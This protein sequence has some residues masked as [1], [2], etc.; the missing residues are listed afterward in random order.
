MQ[1]ADSEHYSKSASENTNLLTVLLHTS[2]STEPSLC[3][4]NPHVFISVII[5][6][7]DSVA[8]GPECCEDI[9]SMSSISLIKL[10]PTVQCIRNARMSVQIYNCTVNVM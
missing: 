10:T 7:S 3:L 8:Q 4:L 5:S 6:D 2:V 9:Y 1:L